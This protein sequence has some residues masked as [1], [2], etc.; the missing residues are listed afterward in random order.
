MERDTQAQEH[1][2]EMRTCMLKGDKTVNMG[3]GGKPENMGGN[4]SKMRQYCTAVVCRYRGKKE[5]S[6]SG[7]PV[8]T[9]LQSTSKSLQHIHQ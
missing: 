7:R 9:G 6:T 4:E 5:Q 8:E 3:E 2:G 1:G